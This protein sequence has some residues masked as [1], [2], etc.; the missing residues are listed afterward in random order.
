M[1]K[2]SLPVDHLSEETRAFLNSCME[3]D[4]AKRTQLLQSD[5]WIGY[6]AARKVID[7]IEGLISMPRLTRMH[8][9]LVIGDTDN[10][11][12]SIR[13]R[14]EQK[15]RH[16][17]TQDSKL[18]VPVVSIQMPPNPSE[19]SFYNAVLRGL[20]LP[21]F[22]SGKI[23][24]IRDSL[25]DN[26]DE[27]AVRLLMVD[28]VQHIDRIPDKKQRA[29]LD[30]MKYLSNELSLPI[31]AFGTSEATNVFAADPQLNNR[32]KKMH[33][34]EWQADDNFRRLLMSI[35]R[36]LPLKEPSELGEETLA[37]AIYSKTNGTIGEIILL[38]RN[39]AIKAIESDSEKITLAIIEELS[40]ESQRKNL[41][42]N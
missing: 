10:G 2:Q 33:L 32:F 17:A 4:K 3:G 12:T 37:F 29:I 7:R 21:G 26:L 13:K 35:E 11:K 20:N 28:E 9:V 15:F 16:Y 38:L 23:D 27:Y 31:A 1:K 5:S 40:F 30:T 19:R 22:A 41:E 24:H 25:V 14:I 42:N 8:S 34:P 39:A 36:L 18:R 6:D